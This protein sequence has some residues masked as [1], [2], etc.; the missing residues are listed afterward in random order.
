MWRLS[1][2]CTGKTKM[3]HVEWIV[4]VMWDSFSQTSVMFVESASCL[5]SGRKGWRGFNQRLCVL[6]SKMGLVIRYA[7]WK[8]SALIIPGM[9]FFW[10]EIL[11]FDIFHFPKNS[12]KS[13]PSPPPPCGLKLVLLLGFMCSEVVVF[14]FTVGEVF[15]RTPRWIW[16]CE[17]AGCFATELVI[18]E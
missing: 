1:R 11:H 5:D 4:W 12:E 2:K 16:S 14:D 15:L 3:M 8:L 7:R 6:T 9:H 13:P 18:T 10:G 17:H